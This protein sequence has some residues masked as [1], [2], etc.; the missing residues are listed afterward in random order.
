MHT[1]KCVSFRMARR[2]WGENGVF[3]NQRDIGKVVLR[4]SKFELKLTKAIKFQTRKLFA[5]FNPLNKSS[6]LL[7]P[8]NAIFSV[9]QSTCWR[10]ERYHCWVNNMDFFHYF[11]LLDRVKCNLDYSMAKFFTGCKGAT[12]KSLIFKGLYVSILVEIIG[13]NPQ[14]YE[15]IELPRRIYN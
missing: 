3:Y 15:H 6:S 4:S 11:S 13:S 5:E 1:L 7:T 14:D 9:S 2:L 10:Q 12:P 8:Y